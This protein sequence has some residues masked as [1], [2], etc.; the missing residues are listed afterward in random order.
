MVFVSLPRRLWLCIFAGFLVFTLLYP[1]L[2]LDN[3]RISCVEETRFLGLVFDCRLTWVPHFRYVNAACMK[4][5]SLLRIIAHTSWGA[6][7]QSILLLH[8]SLIR[9]K[10]EYGC[11]VYPSG[12]E[13]H[14][15]V[16]DSVHHAG[17][18]LATGAFRLPPIP[19]LLVDAGVFPL[20]LR[21]QSLFLGCWYKVHN[22]LNFFTCNCVARLSFS[23]S[24]C[25][26]VFP[27]NFWV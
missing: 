20:D 15:R 14:L 2:Y 23:L 13:A 7:R 12:K 4:A 16:L 18:R 26:P 9:S 27:K 1:D 17:I 22:I 8:Q 6:G 24:S 21:C 3:R 10:L 19:S 5:L 11:E 25:S